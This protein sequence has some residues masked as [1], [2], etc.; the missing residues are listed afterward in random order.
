MGILI[1]KEPYNLN[2]TLHSG[3]AFRWSKLHSPT[4]QDGD[5]HEGIIDGIRV[6]LVQ[7]QDGVKIIT[8]ASNKHLRDLLYKYLAINHDLEAF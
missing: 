1:A 7:S 4:N 6:R 2:E 3:Q 5:L 8:L